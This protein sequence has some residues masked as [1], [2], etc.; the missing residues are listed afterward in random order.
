MQILVQIFIFLQRHLPCKCCIIQVQGFGWITVPGN[1]PDPVPTIKK[2]SY[3]TFLYNRMR[4][5]FFSKS[6]SESDQTTGSIFAGFYSKDPD[7][8]FDKSSYPDPAGSLIG[9]KMQN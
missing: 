2:K 5:I 8:G 7:L 4:Y 6:V 9:K 3:S 1:C